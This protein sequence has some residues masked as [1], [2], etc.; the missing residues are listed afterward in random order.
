MHL[1]FSTVMDSDSRWT[2][3]DLCHF[4]WWW[5]HQSQRRFSSLLFFSSFL[6]Q[7]FSSRLGS[8]CFKLMLLIGWK[9]AFRST[10]KKKMHSF[11][12]ETAS[13]LY[14][15]T[16]VP[17]SPSSSSLPLRNTSF[18]S[19]YFVVYE[20]DIDSLYLIL[21]WA[22]GVRLVC[23]CLC[24]HVFVC[25]YNLSVV[26]LKEHRWNKFKENEWAELNQNV[27]LRAL[28]LQRLTA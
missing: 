19:L 18:S 26:H 23:M 4:A 14:E 25:A 11:P 24:V 20:R 9:R 28:L 17:S 22:L 27:L 21:L 1:A 13:S 7:Y 12:F 2:S 6:P 8:E 16:S 10:K 5:R 3:Y 15:Q